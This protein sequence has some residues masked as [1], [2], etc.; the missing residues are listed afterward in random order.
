MNRKST[1]TAFGE[2]LIEIADKHDFSVFDADLSKA[3][4]TKDFAAKYKSR[5]FNMGISEA[6][7]M[8]HAS[9]FASCGTKV[10]AATFAMF[11]TGRAYEQIRTSIAY[12]NMEVK[13]V[14]THAGVLIGQD[15]ATHQCI[16]DISLMRSIPGMKI[17]VPADALQVKPILVEALS[18][19]GPVYIRLGRSDIGFVYKSEPKSKIGG[20][21]KLRDGKD[22]TIVAMGE[23]V[24]TALDA[25]DDLSK[26]G[27]ECDVINAYS[28]KPINKELILES[29]NKTKKVFTVEDHSIVGG[30]GGAVLQLFSEENQISIKTIGIQDVFGRSGEREDLEKYFGIDKDSIVKKILL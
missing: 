9:G 18:H 19:N 4:C 23:L 24:R 6:D 1:R 11:A 12:A 28:I 27:V 13:V 29:A 10:I 7:M 21:D 17:L 22:A 25:A 2:A 14:G 5:F 8:G 3:T 20:A 30:L 26:K 16:E 15:G